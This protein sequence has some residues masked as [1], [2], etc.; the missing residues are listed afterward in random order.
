MQ[1]EFTAHVRMLDSCVIRE[2]WTV[3]DSLKN[4]GLS[5]IEV[6]FTASNESQELRKSKT[7]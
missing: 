3:L 1:T 2:L 4:F 6:A 5:E 7:L